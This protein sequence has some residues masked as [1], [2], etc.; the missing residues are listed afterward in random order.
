MVH[1]GLQGQIVDIF[2]TTLSTAGF[3][4]GP[5]VKGF[6]QDFASFADHGSALVS[7]AARL[8]FGFSRTFNNEGTNR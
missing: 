4:G 1:H 5:M 6:E 7:A 8:P 2:E 3:I